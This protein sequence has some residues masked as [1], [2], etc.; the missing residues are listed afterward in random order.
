[1]SNTALKGYTTPATSSLAGTWGADL[2]ANFQ[3]IVDVN[4]AGL[5]TIA[6]SSSNVTLSASD[7]QNAMIRLTGTLLASVVLS[8]AGGALF[9]GFYYWEN[10]TGG[11]GF[12]VTVSTG[13]GSVVL[14][15]SRRGV[16]FVDST[17]GPRIVG[18]A[19]SGYADPI[20]VGSQTIWYNSAAPVGWVAVVLNDYAIKIVNSG[21]GGT[22]SGSVAYSTLFGRTATDSH[23]LTSTELPSHSHPFGVVY[24]AAP[25][26]GNQVA[27]VLQTSGGTTIT[28]ATTGSS[29]GHTHDIDMRVLTAAFTLCT[30]A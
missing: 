11:A 9:N 28:T 18:I 29:G 24:G 7:V 23:T 12:T 26:G 20:P 30:K 6:L 16:L 21:S 1:M 5:L 14:P 10:V 13:A 15:Q 19:G 27:S 4:M 17:N 22:V 3:G 25:G 8:P 2:N